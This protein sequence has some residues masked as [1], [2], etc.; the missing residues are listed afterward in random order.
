MGIDPVVHLPHGLDQTFPHIG[1]GGILFLGTISFH[2]GAD[3]VYKAVQTAFPN[4]NYPLKIHGFPVHPHMAQAVKAKP[5]LSR[6]E[7]WGA[8][9]KADVLVLGSRWRENSPLVILEARAAGCP[10]IAPR[11]GGIPELIEEGVDGYLYEI[12]SIED[13]VRALHEWHSGPE[14]SPNPPPTA[15][16]R[17]KALVDWYERAIEQ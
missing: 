6:D 16:K 12:D 15:Q 1:G 17:N 10:V 2:K 4:Q 3:L 9:Q 5:P 8:L 11:T 14:L 13:C 7:V